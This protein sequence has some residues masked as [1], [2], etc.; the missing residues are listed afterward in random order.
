MQEENFFQFKGIESLVL[1]LELSLSLSRLE[2]L[3][4]QETNTKDLKGNS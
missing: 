1:G 2:V 4:S 3:K